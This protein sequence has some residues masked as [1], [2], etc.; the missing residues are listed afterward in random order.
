M[1]CRASQVQFLVKR[2]NMA[3]TGVQA[4][5]DMTPHGATQGRRNPPRG[6]QR[7]RKYLYTRHRERSGR[8]SIFL[9]RYISFY[10]IPGCSE[11][12]L[13]CSEEVLGCPEEIPGCS[14]EI[15]GVSQGGSGAILA[16]LSPRGGTT[17]TR[18]TITNS[19]QVPQHPKRGQV[20]GGG[21]HL[22]QQV[23][24]RANMAKTGVQALADMTP[25]GATQ[26][27]R[28]PPRGCQRGRKYLYTRHR[29]RRK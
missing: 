3:K 23:V 9:R 1:Q 18:K 7:G 25:R 15:P 28:N 21:A 14:E 17:S 8:L 11:E 27:R 29:E 2:A 12:I 10:E 13:G 5:A 20:G 24:K 22:G 4:P 26:G 6:C 19:K 16:P